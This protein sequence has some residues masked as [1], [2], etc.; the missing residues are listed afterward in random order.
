MKSAD[1]MEIL[2]LVIF[3]KYSKLKGM[4]YDSPSKLSVGDVVS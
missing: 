1:K 4:T 2:V 3:S